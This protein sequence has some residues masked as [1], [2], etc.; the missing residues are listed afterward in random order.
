MIK[1]NKYF[2]T[3]ILSTFLLIFPL[4]SCGY[5]QKTLKINSEKSPK[6]PKIVINKIDFGNA[7]SEQRKRIVKQT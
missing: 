5:F 3:K 6:K 2:Y 7:I 4:I 1:N